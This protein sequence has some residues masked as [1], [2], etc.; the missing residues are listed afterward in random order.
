M[1]EY[2]EGPRD[3]VYLLF[4]YCYSMHGDGTFKEAP[5]LFYQFYVIFGERSNFIVP[6]SFCVLKLLKL[7]WL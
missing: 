1:I 3:C 4:I 6:C 5:S 2:V 7:V